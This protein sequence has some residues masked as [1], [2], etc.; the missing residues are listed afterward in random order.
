M[1]I[2]SRHIVAAAAAAAVCSLS[3]TNIH[4]QQPVPQAQEQEPSSKKAAKEQNEL[5][6]VTVTAPRFSSSILKTPPV[7]EWAMRWGARFKPVRELELGLALERYHDKSAGYAGVRDCDQAAGTR[8]ACTLPQE[9]ILINTPGW[10]DFSVNNIRGTA[11]WKLSEH[12]LIDF[13]FVHSDMRRA[14]LRDN[15]AGF[16]PKFPT[17]RVSVEIGNTW[18][19]GTY[20]VN[21]Q[22]VYVPDSKYVSAVLETQIKQNLGSLNYVAGLFWMKE[23]NNINFANELMASGGRTCVK[24]PSPQYS[25]LPWGP[26]SVTNLEVGYKAKLLNNTLN[27]SVAAFYQ[28]YADLQTRVHASRAN[29]LGPACT[30]DPLCNKVSGDATS[31]IGNVNIPGVELEWTYR[32]WQ[33]FKWSGF[34]AYVKPTIHNYD[35]YDDSFQCDVR[36]ELTSASVCPA[37][38]PDSSSDPRK[39]GIRPLDLDGKT[40]PYTPKLTLSSN[41]S[42]DFTLSNGYT[43]APRLSVKWQDKVYFDLSN[44]EDPHIGKYQKAYAKA[45]IGLYIGNADSTVAVDLYLRNVVNTRAK[46]AG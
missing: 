27:I 16:H 36:V 42:Q 24:G 33:G 32:P 12:T 31:N 10:Q 8:Y 37:G 18:P 13:G 1:N 25:A 43:L 45:D 30:T 41:F 2:R 17:Y 29:V 39:R 15:D 19:G 11:N 38:T 44:F 26:E 3:A 6:T 22:L 9:T 21:D 28:R 46:N 5:P 35:V 20:P 14:H 40:L 7:D 34:A 4:A 23:K